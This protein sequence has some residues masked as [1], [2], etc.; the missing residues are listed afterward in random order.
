MLSFLRSW[1]LAFSLLFGV[2]LYWGWM[3]FPWGARHVSSFIDGLSHLQ[4]YLIFTMLFLTFCKSNLLDWRW[5]AWFSTAL[6]VQAGGFLLSAILANLDHPWGILT[7]AA[8]LCFIAPTAT[9]AIVVVGKM[10]GDTEGI[11]IYTV[12]SHLLATFLVPLI[13][14]LLYKTNSVSLP[15]PTLPS[16]FFRIFPLLLG[17][18]FLAYFFRR[19]FPQQHQSLIALKNLA[20]YIWAFSLMLSITIATHHV[21][22]TKASM[23][24]LIGIAGVSLSACTLQF[25]LGRK[26]GAT[27]P[28]SLTASQALGQKNTIFLMWLGYSF[29]H[30]LAAIAGGF[31]AIYHNIWNSYQLFRFNAFTTKQ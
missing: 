17:P 28:Y 16:I 23:P 12:M 4:P 30:P 7:Q 29:F 26:I 19:Y 3:S 14:P 6:C 25:Y 24:L 11:T 22:T 15:S 9:A 21:A 10:Q 20:F 1:M 13:A 5:R 27:F 31:Y 8:M 2:L 18:L